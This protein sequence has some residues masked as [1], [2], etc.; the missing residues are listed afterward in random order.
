[1]KIPIE[2]T[3]VEQKKNLL[4]KMGSIF[5]DENE[6]GTNK[7]ITTIYLQIECLFAVNSNKCTTSDFCDLI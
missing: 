1:M 4:Q 7:K 2:M 5:S 6:L 3:P